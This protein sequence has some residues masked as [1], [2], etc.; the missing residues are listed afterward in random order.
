VKLEGVFPPAITPFKEDD[1]VDVEKLTEYLDF[2]VK[3]RVHGIFLLGTNGEGPLL[4]HEE[5]KLLIK[6][7]VEHVNGRIPIIVGTGCTSTKETVELSKYA[8]KVGADAIHV[9]TPYYYPVSEEGFIRHYNKIT[10]SV[11]LP[12]IIYYIPERTGVKM[13]VSTLLKLAHN[14]KIIGIKDSSKSIEWFYE[15][16]NTVKR[17]R[18][19][20]V[21]FGGSDALIYVHLVLGAS[22]VVSAVANVFPEIVVE[23]YE[24]F[25][26]GNLQKAKQLQDKILAIRRS[27][28]MGPYLGGVKAALKLRGMDFGDPRSPLV[29]YSNKELEELEKKLEEI[30]IIR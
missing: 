21:F 28:K 6:T 2:L 27:L 12:L 9:V 5:K 11:E 26:R 10:E 25:R 13:S 8:E 29:G 4:T 17:I 7:A 22:G 15:A 20:F 16:I 23:L 30:G 3:N 24:E 18:E 19:D 14:E 1:E